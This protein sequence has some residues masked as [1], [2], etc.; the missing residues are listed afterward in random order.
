MSY[1]I[2]II[3]EGKYVHVIH[4]GII[5]K[6][7]VIEIVEKL[8]H[9]PEIRELNYNLLSD[10]EQAKVVLQSSDIK[11]VEH[12]LKVDFPIMN[13]NRNAIIA[14]SPMVAAA[15]LALEKSFSELDVVFKTFSTLEGALNWL[16]I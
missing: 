10:F 4:R 11:E 15:S 9:M 8:Y 2:D 6:D 1:Q 14:T 3:T 12:A 16:H 13:H 7:I 5:T